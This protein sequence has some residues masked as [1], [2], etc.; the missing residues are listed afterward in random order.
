MQSGDLSEKDGRQICFMEEQKC[1]DAATLL[2][3][4]GN[5]RL[6]G[7][8]Q[9]QL[10]V[11]GYPVITTADGESV[12]SLALHHSLSCVL[13][14]LNLPLRDGLEVCRLLR[15]EQKTAYL[16]IFMI[17]N[18]SDETEAIIS[19]EVG[20]DDYISVPF[21]WQILRARLRA[22]LR[23][24]RYSQD[25]L[26]SQ[27]EEGKDHLLQREQEHEITIGNLSMNL[28]GRT[29]MQNGQPIRLSSRLFE[30]LW[31][32]VQHCGMVLTR[33]QLAAFL[34]GNQEEMPDDRFID[35]YIHLLREK[36]HGQSPSIQTIRGVGY[37]FSE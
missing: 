8:L 5:A 10:Q 16:P 37:R 15:T 33:K 11:E 28:A 30:L 7:T 36:L 20:A 22:L 2:L 27:Q 9:S 35:T 6:R 21:H 29:V 3:A 4:I 14:D 24:S 1:P 23:R 26:A 32:F 34:Q 25:E 13:L 18:K 12:L 17:A 31:Y 19:L